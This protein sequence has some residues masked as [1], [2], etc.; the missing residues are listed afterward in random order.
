[1]QQLMYV[2]TYMYIEIYNS[3]IFCGFFNAM[4]ELIIS[5]PCS[6]PSE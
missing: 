4:V 6:Q 2:H 5:Y 3:I 1:M